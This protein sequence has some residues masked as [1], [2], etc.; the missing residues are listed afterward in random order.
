LIAALAACSSQKDPATAAVKAARDAYK[1]VD[2][3]DMRY[4]AAEAKGVRDAVENS[5]AALER[6]AYPLAIQEATGVPERVAKL[7]TAIATR[8]ADLTASWTKMSTAVPPFM[9]AINNRLKGGGGLAKPDAE[10]ARA[11]M[12]SVSNAWTEAEVAAQSG[13]V[14]TAASKAGDV[15]GALVAMAGKLKMKV[16]A[17][18][19]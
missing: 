11:E 14:G 18:L 15:K 4:A 3:S 17:D 2:A 10:K 19:Q 16:P 13:D 5:E 9:T 8:K 6:A 7:K 12:E 1:T